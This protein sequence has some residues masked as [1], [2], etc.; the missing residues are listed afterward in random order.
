M[1]AP[2]R[3]DYDIEIFVSIFKQVLTLY[4]TFQKF[5]VVFGLSTQLFLCVPGSRH[6][7]EAHARERPSRA[8][9]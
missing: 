7:D 4:N 9:V 6:G 5:F 1:D 2:K 3:Y 8:R